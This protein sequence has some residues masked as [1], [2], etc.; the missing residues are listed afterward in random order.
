MALLSSKLILSIELAEWIA[1]CVCVA[2]NESFRT[3]SN[4]Q[5]TG[6][7]SN[8]QMPINDVNRFCAQTRSNA[9]CNKTKCEIMCNLGDDR[10]FKQKSELDIGRFLKRLERS[11]AIAR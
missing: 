7:W 6:T 1:E 3:N 4:G 8:Y 11:K 5:T 10:H 9:K 2:L